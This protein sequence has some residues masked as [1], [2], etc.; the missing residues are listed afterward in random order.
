VVAV[1]ATCAATPAVAAAP[2]RA[3]LSDFVCQQARQ[4]P[5]RYIYV[6]AVMRARPGTQRMEMRFQLLQR[7]P[8]SARWQRMRGRYLNTW[9]HPDIATLGQ[10]PGD[11]WQEKKQVASLPAPAVYRLRVSFRW[12]L[13]GGHLDSVLRSP[14]CREG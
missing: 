10:Q 7:T 6:L 4:A 12:E 11:V 3:Q 5:N 9:I 2:P 14:R 1:L 13:A 8:G